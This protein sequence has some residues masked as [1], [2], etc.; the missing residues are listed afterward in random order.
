MTAVFEEV[1]RILRPDGT[2]WLNMGDSYCAK[3]PGGGGDGLQRTNRGTKI[4]GG[5]GFTGLKP[6]DL[7]G[8]PWAMAFALRAAGWYLRSEIIWAKKNGMPESV[9]D[10]PTRSHEQIFLMTK[11]PKYYYDAEAIFEPCAHST[12][13]DKRLLDENYE[14]A[15]SERGF[16]GQPQYGSGLLKRKKKE[17]PN[18]KMF[19]E[20]QPGK[21]D[22]K[23]SRDYETQGGTALEMRNKR[24]VWEIATTPFKEAH[25]A[26]F[27]AKLV[28]PCILAGSRPGD[29]VMDPFSGAGTVGKVASERGRRYLGIELY[30]KN[31]E[32]T[33]RRM[34]KVQ[35]GL[36]L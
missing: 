9:T 34:M 14:T 18:S 6:K 29:W 12:L 10:R 13:I 17:G 33:D 11:S 20:R 8:Q 25:Y 2:L 16:P 4:K 36:G 22:S 32:I 26:T 30:Q 27:P 3:N 15:R 35:P 21:E 7:I 1:R 28:E 23:P 24:D 31:I 19:K 5:Q